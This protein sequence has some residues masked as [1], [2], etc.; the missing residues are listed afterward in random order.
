MVLASILNCSQEIF[1]P[2]TPYP[3]GNANLASHVSLNFWP[4]RLNPSTPLEVPIASVW[5]QGHGHF[6]ELYNFGFIR[7]RIYCIVLSPA[8]PCLNYWYRGMPHS[9]R[10]LSCFSLKLVNIEFCHFGQK[11]SFH[12][13]TSVRNWGLFEGTTRGNQCASLT[14]KHRNMVWHDT[15]QFVASNKQ[16]SLLQMA[17]DMIYYTF[18]AI[19]R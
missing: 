4:V 14:S 9:Q 15:W 3:S 18:W 8:L 10:L 5:G 16:I 7:I 13:M 2:T 11:L 19:V 6:L 12:H 17:M 1:P